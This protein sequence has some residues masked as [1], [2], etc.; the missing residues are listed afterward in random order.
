MAGANVYAAKL[1]ISPIT[2]E[3]SAKVN[4]E[5]LACDH[6]SPPYWILKV[7]IVVS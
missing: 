1:A 7:A 2:T 5:G 4:K 3:A 6:A